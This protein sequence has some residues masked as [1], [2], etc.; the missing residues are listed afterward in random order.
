MASWRLL[1]CIMSLV[2]R[3]RVDNLTAEFGT[4]VAFSF[5][6]LCEEIH[7][8]VVPGTGNVVPSLGYSI[9]LSFVNPL[10]ASTRHEFLAG[11]LT[12]RYCP[13]LVV[14]VQVVV[15]LAIPCTYAQNACRTCL[16]LASNKVKYCDGSLSK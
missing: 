15:W 2:I 10:V 13:R 1:S 6:F 12:A 16:S 11:Q 9:P 14:Y 8:Q 3:V 5:I 4:R 7:N